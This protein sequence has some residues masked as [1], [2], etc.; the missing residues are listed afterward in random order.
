MKLSVLYGYIFSSH[1][2]DAKAEYNLG[3]C[4]E[5]GEGVP[6]DIDQAVSWYRKAA[7]QG[8]AKAQSNLGVCYF[9]GWG[10]TKNREEAVYWYRK[11]AEQGQNF[12]I[13]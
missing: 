9:N 13:R 8:N 6:K 1:K 2:G 12:R 5:R 3:V 7:A 10:L 4:C 11:A